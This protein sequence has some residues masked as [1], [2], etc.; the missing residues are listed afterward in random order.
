MVHLDALADFSLIKIA[1]LV[2]ARSFQLLLPLGAYGSEDVPLEH[3]E[4]GVIH[5]QCLVH[6]N[7]LKRRA[8]SKPTADSAKAAYDKKLNRRAVEVRL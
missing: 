1:T 7:S 3:R 5:E 6:I 8:L 4:F 2:A